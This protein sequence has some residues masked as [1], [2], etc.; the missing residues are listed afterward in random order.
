[1]E[2]AKI[3]TSHLGGLKRKLE[4]HIS[5]EQV[6]GVFDEIYRKK[7]KTLER[8]GFRKGKVPLSQIRSIYK[9]EV[10]KDA[11]IHLVNESY[12]EAL[13]REQLR[14]AGEPKISLKSAVM[15]NEAFD[16]SAELE[17]QPEIQLDSA[18][19]VT[20]SKPSLKVEEKEVEKALENIRSASASFEP[21]KENRGVKWGDVVRLEVKELSQPP[22]GVEK[23]PLLEMNKENE[24]EIKGLMEALLDMKPGEERKVKV[25]LSDEYPI[26]ESAGKSMEWEVVLKDIQKKNVPDLDEEFIK[27]FKCKDIDHLKSLIRQSIE[28]EKQTHSYDV[29]REEA[30]KQL[31]EK[32]PVELLP[33]GV[34]EEQKQAII[35]SVEDRLKQSNMKEKDIQQ[36]KKKHQEEFQKQARFMVQSSYL[37][38]AL[39]SQANISVSSQEVRLYLQK[40]RGEPV[41]EEYERV[42]N[43]LIREKTI[44][45]LVHTAVKV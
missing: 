10:Q 30:L 2:I 23:T 5:A 18:F 40:S 13:D 42:K 16:F 35:S 33:E 26:K 24:K 34:V 45:H 1:M 32:N 9:Q 27:K 11:T 19:K 3:S 44:E 37:I 22:I 29:M 38:H 17:I 28:K 41:E 43:F 36:Y 14:P 31:V 4:I 21:I 25:H 15:E 6:R 8:P 7:Q 12:K 39:A 20:L